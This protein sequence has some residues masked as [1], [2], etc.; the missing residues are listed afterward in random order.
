[1]TNNEKIKT[2]IF[3]VL[4]LHAL[5]LVYKLVCYGWRDALRF[6]PLVAIWIVVALFAAFTQK[7]RVKDPS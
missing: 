6:S 2:G 4:G 3:T 7:T 1:M 5:I